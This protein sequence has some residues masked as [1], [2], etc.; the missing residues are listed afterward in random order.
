[1]DTDGHGFQAAKKRNRRKV[2]QKYDKTL[3]HLKQS[4]AHLPAA[5]ATRN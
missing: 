3:L 2:F 1:M 4:F 5:E